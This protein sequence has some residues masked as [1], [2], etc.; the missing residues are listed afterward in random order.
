[1]L[2]T[3]IIVAVIVIIIKAW[4]KIDQ[5]LNWTGARFGEATDVVSDVTRSA[6]KQT[7]RGVLISHGSL[8]ETINLEKQADIERTRAMT[9]FTEKCTEDELKHIAKEDDLY[10]ALLNR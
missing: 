8:K 6:S 10:N 2:E 4:S 9:K 7:A 3:I 1:M 5:A